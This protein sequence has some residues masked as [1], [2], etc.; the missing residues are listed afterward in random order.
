MCQ[1]NKRARKR[2]FCRLS[3]H[4][5]HS[6]FQMSYQN[7]EARAFICIKLKYVMISHTELIFQWNPMEYIY[8][9]VYSG[10][11]YSVNFEN[12]DE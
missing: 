12:E 9:R 3:F 2:K 6:A 5:S 4:I 1:T 7:F 8:I 10:I 11:S